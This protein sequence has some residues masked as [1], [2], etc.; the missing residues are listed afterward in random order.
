VV[1]F[2]GYRLVGYW[3]NNRL[4]LLSHRSHS[5]SVVRTY[6]RP[7]DGASNEQA[8]DTASDR[9]IRMRYLRFILV[10][11]TVVALGFLLLQ[12][13]CLLRSHLALK[14]IVG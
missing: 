3:C 14:L 9:P 8:N 1:R 6:C 13:L 5:N 4:G 12:K 2:S 11:L 7:A 10:A